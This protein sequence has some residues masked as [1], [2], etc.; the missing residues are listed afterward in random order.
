[1]VSIELYKDCL[2][3]LRLDIVHLDDYPL[4]FD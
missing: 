1:M 2:N 4:D 3:L